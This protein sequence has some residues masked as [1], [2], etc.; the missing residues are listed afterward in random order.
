MEILWKS[1]WTEGLRSLKGIRAPQKNHQSQLTWTLVV[2]QKQNHPPKGKHELILGHLLPHML[3]MCNLIFMLIS[4]QLEQG[5]SLK[6]F[7]ICGIYALSGLSGRG[8]A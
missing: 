4:Q 6:I 1:W 2:S 3:Q 8:Y 7:P 5:L